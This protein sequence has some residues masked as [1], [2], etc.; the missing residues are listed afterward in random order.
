MRRHYSCLNINHILLVHSTNLLNNVLLTNT[1]TYIHTLISSSD[2]METCIQ[3]KFIWNCNEYLDWLPRWSSGRLC[4]WRTRGLRF[5][6]RVGQSITGFFSDFRKF[7]YYIKNNTVWAH[8]LL[9]KLLL[10]TF[11]YLSMRSL[12]G[13]K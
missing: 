1:N 2:H 4:N 7:L 6:F 9:K 13:S 11:I 10:D 8:L 12:E 3:N 5:D